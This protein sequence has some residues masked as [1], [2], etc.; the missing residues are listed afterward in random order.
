VSVLDWFFEPA[1][2]RALDVPAG[3]GRRGRRGRAEAAEGALARSRARGPRMDPPAGSVPLTAAVLGP[4]G[5]VEPVAASVLSALRRRSRAGAAV[6]ALL[7]DPSPPA[8]RSLDAG[9]VAPGA[10][11]PVRGAA[12]TEQG[13]SGRGPARELAARLEGR[14]LASVA[15]G[16]V[17]RILLPAEGTVSA[18]HRAAAVGAPTV[19]A[20][21]AP[22]TPALDELLAAQDLLVLVAGDAA[23]PLAA[24]AREELARLG[25]PLATVPAP[26]GGPVGAL[27]RAGILPGRLGPELDAVLAREGSRA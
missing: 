21:T 1:D 10:D 26:P 20:V 8:A 19:L 14:G 9:A 15:H 24:L 3:S 23:D 7:A 25:P 18:A 27:V 6:L 5:A 4:A 16:R 2:P 22:R 17:V 12:V 11:E 13:G